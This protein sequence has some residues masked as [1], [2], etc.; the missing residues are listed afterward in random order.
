MPKPLPA[1][2]DAN[3]LPLA[4]LKVLDLTR[5]IAGPVAGQ[6]LALYGADVTWGKFPFRLL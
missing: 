6:T 3:D 4:G 1:L 5:V 2:V